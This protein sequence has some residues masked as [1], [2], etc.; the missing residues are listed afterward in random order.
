MH[1]VGEIGSQAVDVNV[2]VNLC[3]VNFDACCAG[4]V[5]AAVSDWVVRDRSQDRF[6]SGLS[7]RCERGGAQ[8]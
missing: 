7:V 3:A 5:G 8:D 4:D 1:G 6:E 2:D